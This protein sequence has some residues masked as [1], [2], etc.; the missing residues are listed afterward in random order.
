MNNELKEAGIDWRITE[1]FPPPRD[2]HKN[3]CHKNN[4]PT[5]GNCVDANFT[6]ATQATDA[7][8]KKFIQTANNNGFRAVWEV[9]SVA[10]ENRLKAAG[11]PASNVKY[12]GHSTAP[13]FSV[14]N[15]SIFK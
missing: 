12:I 14:Y 3:P 13:H 11:I 10:E 2:I 7:N 9:N 8:V 1:G 6:G 5:S 15:K 4:T